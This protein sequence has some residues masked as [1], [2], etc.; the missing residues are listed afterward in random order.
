MIKY[1]YLVILLFSS[2]YSINAQKPAKYIDVIK[3]TL[4]QQQE[5]WNNGDIDAFMQA[6]WK[7][8]HLQF[9]GAS[10]ITRGWAQ[11]LKN[12]KARYPDKE[13]MG[14]L[15]FEIKDITPHSKKV[16]SLT[17]SWQLERKNDR[18]GG[19]FILIWRKINGDWKIVADHT[20]SKS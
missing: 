16:V 3:Q 4:L 1:L 19:H 6:Y 9:G 13:T 2:T 15:T 5:D 14:K 18:P 10:G 12:Y 11:T 8:E 20:S 7:S 17:G